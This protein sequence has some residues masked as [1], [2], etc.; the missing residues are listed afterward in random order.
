MGDNI[1]C[2]D[3]R[4]PAVNEKASDKN[5]TAF[6]CGNPKSDCHKSFLYISMDGNKQDYLCWSG[7]EHGER[8]VEA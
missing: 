3:C 7:C 8:R 2:A 5:W 1:R 6:V 4:F